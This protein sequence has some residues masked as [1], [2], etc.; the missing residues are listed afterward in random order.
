MPKIQ[1]LL[2]ADATFKKGASINA[3]GGVALEVNHV[4]GFMSVGRVEEVVESNLEQSSEGRVGGEMSADA[5]VFLVLAMD[6]GHG[7]PANEG[8]DATFHIAIARV[9]QLL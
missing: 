8:F 3:R 7:V 6:H 5:R 9:R 2:L 4:S 1:N